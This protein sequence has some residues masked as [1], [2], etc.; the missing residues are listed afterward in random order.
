VDLDSNYRNVEQYPNST[1]F[2]IGFAK[3][4]QTGAFPQGLPYNPSSYFE[5]VS[6]DPDYLNTDIYITG[7]YI[8]NLKLQSD[9]VYICGHAAD[10]SVINFYYLS[11]L[12]VTIPAAYG[13]EGFIVKFTINTS[14]NAVIPYIF[15]WAV[16]TNNSQSVSRSEGY[17]SR[18]TFT[19][20]LGGNI[21]FATEFA[22]MMLDVKGISSSNLTPFTLLT[23]NRPGPLL[24]NQTCVLVLYLNTID[25]TL[26]SFNGI[27]WGYHIFYSNY[28]LEN[29]LSNG[30]INIAVDQGN[31][32]ICSLNT[33][34][35]QLPT[36]Y[37]PRLNNYP[38]TNRGV[39]IN[40]D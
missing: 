34:P 32:L 15:N 20:D 25:G 37:N 2:A 9:S 13:P 21:Y 36:Y 18:A 30:R 33:N 8:D 23:L 6:I 5:D 24:T 22:S 38:P 17:N 26:G 27:N 11:N 31:N 40:T 10:T 3:N 29:T 1:D 16:Y 4:T 12:L 19:F 28:H 7:G 35:Y 14:T 39:G